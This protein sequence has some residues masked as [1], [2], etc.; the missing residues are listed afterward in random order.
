MTPPEKAWLLDLD[1]TLYKSGPLKLVMGA[2]L[3][4]LGLGVIGTVRTFRQEHEHLREELAK[5][6]LLCFEPSPLAE[7][8][9]RTAA[10]TGKSESAVLAVVERWM[11]DKPARYLRRFERASLIEEIRAFR[12]AGGRTA[13]ISDYPARRKLQALGVDDLFDVVVSN[14]E[15]PKLKRLKPAPDGVLLAASELGVPPEHCLVIGDREDAD[16]AA[17]RAAGMTFRL[18]R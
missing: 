9:R 18:V 4:L 17:A 7:Q 10:A 8:V 15:H 11:V 2:E 3:V 13:V 6:P 5:D 12:A 1:G 14:G 16:G